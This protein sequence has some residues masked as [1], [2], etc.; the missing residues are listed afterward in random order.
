MGKIIQLIL[1]LAITYSSSFAENSPAKVGIIK[2]VVI[3]NNSGKKM[4]YATVSVLDFNTNK[5]ITGAM[6]N[7]NGSFIFKNIKFGKYKL[8]ATFIGY[9]SFFIKSIVLNKKNKI[10]NAGIIKLNVSSKNI[11]EVEIVADRPSVSYNIDKKVINVSQQTTATAGTAVDILESVPSIKVD[12]EGNVSLRGSTGFEVYIDGRPSILEASDILQQIPSSS[13]EN[14]EIITNPSA[15]YDPEGTA[16]I[17]NIVLKKGKLKGFS[18]IVN[19]NIGTQD[20]YGS[21]FTFTLNKK[22][23]KYFLSGDFNQRNYESDVESERNFTNSDG[24]LLANKGSGEASRKRKR[25]SFKFMTEISLNQNNIINLGTR[26]GQYHVNFVTDKI[27]KDVDTPTKPIQRTVSD[28]ERKGTFYSFNLDYTHYFNDNKKHKL[29]FRSMLMRRDGDEDSFNK[30]Y[31][32]NNIQNSGNVYTEDGPSGGF[33]INVD[34]TL[35][36]NKDTKFETGYQL[37]NGASEDNNTGKIYD[38]ASKS[39]NPIP[40]YS[41]GADYERFIHSLYATYSSKLG[42]F[43][44][45]AGFRIQETTRKVSWSKSNDDSDIDRFDFFPTIHLSYELNEKGQ[46]MAS[47]TKRIETVRGWYLEPFITRNNLYSYRTGNPNLNPEYIDSYEVGYL[48]HFE[49][50]FLSLESYYR[51]KSDKVEW[52][53]VPYKKDDATLRFP[54]NIGNTDTYGIEL[55]LNYNITKWWKSDIT[56]NLFNYKVKGEY[57][58]DENVYDI[59][60]TNIDKVQK[61]DNN[62]DS[63][64]LRFNN[65]FN[66]SKNTKFQLN[67]RY[68]S[69]VVTSQGHDAEMLR[70]DAALKHMMFKRKLTLTLQAKDLFAS[71]I[72]ESLIDSPTLWQRN[73]STPVSTMINFTASYKFNN[74]K[75]KKKRNK[76]DM[77]GDDF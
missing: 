51:H 14:I 56:F 41:N 11:S 59:S 27:V 71:A 7:K 24:E 67:A 42:N 18:G 39:Y 58:I 20:N 73:K 48:K 33:R 54:E 74:F 19:A 5:I 22:K 26:V 45:Q 63:W 12:V 1:I 17:V 66:F 77:G 52:I 16:G 57:I 35:P 62:S 38:S 23:V 9:E 29:D 60:K 76:G 4:E 15:K 8:K 37:R 72:H 55:M 2:G 10:F 68:D 61:F 36:I 46:F 6:T 34:Y 13:I 65:S 44:Y 30:I 3:D 50:G 64:T 40:D 75:Q 25:S 53:R 49:K 21:D 43:G 69:K 31:D 70:I 28:F 32:I 47:Y